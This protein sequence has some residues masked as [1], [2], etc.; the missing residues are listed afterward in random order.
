MDA[1]GEIPGS[2]HESLM[3]QSDQIV[4]ETVYISMEKRLSFI[5]CSTTAFAFEN[6]S[7]KADF[8]DKIIQLKIRVLKE[9]A[10]L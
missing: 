7:F 5:L 8:N 3:I 2:I 9:N 1:P 10:F 4:Q 6:N